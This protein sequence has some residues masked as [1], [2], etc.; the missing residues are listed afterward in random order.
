MINLC[1]TNKQFPQKYIEDMNKM[2]KKLNFKQKNSKHLCNLILKGIE[3]ISPKNKDSFQYAAN[4]YNELLQLS[5]KDSI[6][7]QVSLVYLSN[8]ILTYCFIN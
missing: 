1:R 3:L 2:Y 4:V 8:I 7:L 6:S 5:K